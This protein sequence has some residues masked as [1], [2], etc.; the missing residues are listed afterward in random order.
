MAQSEFKTNLIYSDIAP[1]ADVSVPANVWT[2][3]ANKQVSAQQ[4]LTFGTGAI[5]GGVDDR[6]TIKASFYSTTAVIGDKIRIQLNNAQRRNPIVLMETSVTAMTAGVKLS[7]GAF[8][9]KGRPYFAKEDSYLE[10]A[11]LSSSAAT[12]DYDSAS[13]TASI[14]VTEIS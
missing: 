14:D 2:V 6:G 7:R 11:M 5:T 1:S 12:L 13:N 9:E 4:M 8:Q 3:V 10:I